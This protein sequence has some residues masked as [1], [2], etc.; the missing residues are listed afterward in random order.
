LAA[1]CRTS[2]WENPNLVANYKKYHNK[3]FEIYQVSLD[4]TKNTWVKAIKRD[5]LTWY[6]VSDLQYWNCAPAQ[7]Y[8]VQGIPANFLIDKQGKI[9]AKN[10][11]GPALGMKLSEIF[12]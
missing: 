1:W 3:G 12:D 2:R 11:R 8:N 5:N 10:I 6:H 9:I 7:V 4:R